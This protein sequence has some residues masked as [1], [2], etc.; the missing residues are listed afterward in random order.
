MSLCLP[1]TDGGF[2]QQTPE[3]TYTRFKHLVSPVCGPVSQLGPMPGRHT[4]SRPVYVSG[5]RVCPKSKAVNGQ[6]FQ[7]VC[8]GKGQ[9]EQQAKVSALFEAIERF[10]GIYQGD[11][12]IV[13]GSMN[14]MGD[15]AISPH[16]LQL[17]SDKQYET[18]GRQRE[19]DIENALRVTK[20]YEPEQV[21]DWTPA[22]S[23]SHNKPRFVPFTY[24][25]TEVPSLI[26]NSFT[27]H[28]GNGVASGTCFE[29]A[30]LQGFFELVER[31]AVGIWWY[32]KASRPQINLAQIEDE[33]YLQ[34][35]EEYNQL[36]CN[37]WILDLTHDLRIP[38]YTALAQKKNEER[39][40]IGFGCH[41]DWKIA[42]RRAL[43]ELNQLFDPAGDL[44][45]PWDHQQLHSTAFL[46]PDNT[47]YQIPLSDYG[48]SSSMLE[49]IE[50]CMLRLHQIGLE[51]VVVN[52]SR[53]DTGVYVAHVIVPGLRHFWPRFG[54]G[55]L[56]TVPVQ[57]GWQNTLR[58]EDELNSVP[59]LL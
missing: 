2:R 26:D 24:C 53:P 22:W 8:A 58:S 49:D 20:K 55:R 9:S 57:L 11:E 32:N 27:L 34:M 15:E 10:S 42:L 56:Y 59:L 30:I 45:A 50:E 39:F 54:D 46:Y 5:Y 1:C 17:F 48:A 3:T 36:G 29:E 44:H 37:I 12:A 18:Y 41:L 31:D 25:Y 21:I 40:S 38:V 16:S 19:Q 14:E 4:F 47:A 52:K 51:L 35:K 13:R 28:N 7:R 6:S 33:Y 23:L 43:T